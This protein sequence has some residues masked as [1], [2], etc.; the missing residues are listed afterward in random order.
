MRSIDALV[1]LVL[2][3]GHGYAQG[4]PGEPGLA[5]RAAKALTAER[6]GPGFVDD[7]VLLV[8]EGRI[9]AVGRAADVPI[10]AGFHVLDVRPNW[11][12]P[13]MIDLHTHT[14]G[15]GGYNDMVFQ[16]NSGLRVSADV[17]PMNPLLRRELEGGITTV[18][19][20][21]GSGTNMGGAGV[22]LK[23]GFE[24]FEEMRVR[25]PGSLKV[26]Q[27]DNPTAWGYRMGRSMMNYHIRTTF[28]RGRAYAERWEA[29]GEGTNGEP[30]PERNLT[31]DIFRELFAGRTQVS[32]HT[33]VY[34]L[35]LMT[36]TMIK[37]EFGIDVYIDHGEW[38]GFKTAELAQKMGVAAIIG[39]REIDLFGDPRF[40]T[41]GAILSVSGEYQK[42]GLQQIGFN[43]DAGVVDGEQLPLQAAMGVRYG[44]DNSRMDAVRGLTIIPAQVAG[45][46]DRVG[47]LEPGKDADILVISGDP[48]DPRHGIEMIWVEGRRVY[49]AE[50]VRR[51]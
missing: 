15:G 12:M 37:G 25:D 35:V 9:R 40:D 11:V 49:E 31:Y 41:D 2:F 22:L 5:I 34:Q 48:A 10:P 33:Q 44:F 23:T 6:H 8:E 27:G 24:S 46:A 38:T 32:T 26:A 47:S 18:L 42:R 20:I 43:T 3:A 50:G 51:W 14:A 36:I 13:G 16:I 21:P 7:A 19:F 29:H 1:V 45:I 30:R 39:P 28:R 4:A 17:M